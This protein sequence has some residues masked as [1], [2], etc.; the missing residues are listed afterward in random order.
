M[1]IF[2]K[3]EFQPKSQS[4]F[5]PASL[6]LNHVDR[7]MLLMWLTDYLLNTASYSFH[8]AAGRLT[9]T[10]T[11]KLIPKNVPFH[12]NTSSFKPL[13][14]SLY[15]RIPDKDM[16]VLRATKPPNVKITLEGGELVAYGNAPVEVTLPN[17]KTVTAFT[18]AL[19]IYRYGCIC[20]DSP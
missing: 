20:S 15:K 9:Y 13:V 12:L 16:Q 7:Q 8:Q 3:G 18:L 2:F 1:A 5:V 4:P 10:V 14:P 19:T 11:P 6:P 17:E